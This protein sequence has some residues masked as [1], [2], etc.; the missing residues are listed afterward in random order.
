MVGQ[1]TTGKEAAVVAEVA[2]AVPPELGGDVGGEN[3]V[4]VPAPAG[5]FEVVPCDCT[6]MEV[7][8]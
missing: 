3:T 2:A 6:W 5:R 8:E 7:P 1:I 4:V